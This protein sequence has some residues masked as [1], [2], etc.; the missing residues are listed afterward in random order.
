MKCSSMY[1]KSTVV[2]QN[3]FTGIDV[4][5]SQKLAPLKTLLIVYLSCNQNIKFYI[6]SWEFNNFYCVVPYYGKGRLHESDAN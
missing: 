5:F 4:K 3:Y 1:S 6:F 2:I